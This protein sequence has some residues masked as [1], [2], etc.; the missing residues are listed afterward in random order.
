MRQR[1]YDVRLSAGTILGG[2][3]LDPIIPPSVLAI[4][5]ATLAEVST[6]KLLIAGIVPGLLLTVMFL[7]YVTVRV[8]IDPSLAPDIA[9]DDRKTGGSAWMALLR[10]LPSS[11]IFFMV[12]GLVMIGAATPTEAA[13]T[14]VV[15]AL[16]LAYCYGGLSFTMVGEALRAAVTVS[17]LLLLI[18]CCAVMFSQLL[19]F[20]GAPQALGKIVVDLALPA[21]IM[22]FLMLA[23]PFVLFLFL[24]QVALMLVLTP[25]YL[26]I[27]RTYGVDEIWFWTQF[28]VVATVGG[29]SPPFGY[30]LFAMKSA[31]PDLP[32]SEIYSAAWPFVWIITAGMFF[33]ALVPSTITF[34]PR[35]M[36]P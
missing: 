30:T 23:L 33:M 3:S 24:D 16:I 4:I 20:A 18:M 19:T 22:V 5:I 26:P 7:V 1:G 27:L 28:L 14:G 2:A 10:M 29:I 35:L 34:L 17:S 8:W 31:A 15:G 21:P 12:M 6:G 9:A 25:I 32:M 11:F 36:G 13:A